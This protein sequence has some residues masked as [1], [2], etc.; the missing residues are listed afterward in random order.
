MT[1]PGYRTYRPPA[2]PRRDALAASSLALGFLG[3]ALLAV[4]L[5]GL[6][7]A[8]FGFVLGVVALVRRGGRPRM[9]AAGVAVSGVVLVVGSIA[10]VVLLDKAAKCGDADRFPDDAA[11]KVCVEREFPFAQAR[12]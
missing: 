1:M 10:L 8:L 2:P 5:L 9:A 12:D 6:L 3:L 4:C 7:P 11:R